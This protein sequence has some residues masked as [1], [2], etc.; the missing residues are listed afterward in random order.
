MLLN[1]GARAEN[2]ADFLKVAD[3]CVVGS[4]LKYDGDTWNRLDP[5]RV[6]RFVEAAR[7]S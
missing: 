3:G 4:S 6:R 1:T 2:I 7:S 5:A